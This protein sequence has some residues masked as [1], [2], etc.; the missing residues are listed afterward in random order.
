MTVRRHRCFTGHRPANK[1]ICFLLAGV[2]LLL[3]LGGAAF[4][5]WRLSGPAAEI[6]DGPPHVTTPWDQETVPFFLEEDQGQCTFTLEQ[7]QETFGEDISFTFDNCPSLGNDI[8]AYLLNSFRMAALVNSRGEKSSENQYA[9]FHPH[10]EGDSVCILL[11]YDGT[12]HLMGYFI[13]LPQEEEDG[14]WRMDVTLCSY[15]FSSLYRQQL[16]EYPR[17]APHLFTRFIPLD[18]LEESGAVWCLRGYETS[19]SLTVQPT[20]P[21]CYH[22]WRVVNSPYLERMLSPV[23]SIFQSTYQNGKWTCFLLYDQDLHLLGY[24]MWGGET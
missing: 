15:E 4:A 21:Q 17:G 22:L 24:T 20:D 10:K 5:L 23:K 13:G 18:D 12:T 1:K 14:R 19:S 8:D 6:E 11:L 3:L 7:L 2:F 16:E 9:T